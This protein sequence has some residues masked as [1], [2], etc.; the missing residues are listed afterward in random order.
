MPSGRE[1]TPFLHSYSTLPLT[2]LTQGEYKN[3][4]CAN[5][6]SAIYEGH[7]DQAWADAQQEIL[8][9]LEASLPD[10]IPPQRFRGINGDNFAGEPK[11]DPSA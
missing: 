8:L 3:C 10:V 2:F 11:A 7:F 6:V 4:P 5:W 9:E 1:F